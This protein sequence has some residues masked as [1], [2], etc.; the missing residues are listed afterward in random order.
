MNGEWM[1]KQYLLTWIFK[2]GHGICAFVRTPSRDGMLIDCGGSHEIIDALDEY[3]LPSC[4]EHENGFLD[5]TRTAQ[6]LISHP[7]VDHFLQ[8][9][10][11]KQLRPCFWTCP[12]DKD[13]LLGYP[14]ERLDWQLV[15][16]PDG[17][18][19]LEE[20]YRDA[21]SKRVLPLQAFVPANEI[22]HFSYGL[23]Y[24]PPPQ[25]KPVEPKVTE[26][27]DPLPKRDYAN[28]TS[29]MAYF[30]FNK[31]SILMPGDMMESG[32]ER[33]LTVGC[34]SRIVGDD[35]QARFAKQSAP[36][37]TF[38]KWVNR[39]CSVLV[40]PHH[41]L[42]SAYSPE[43]FRSLPAADPRVG[44][45]IISEKAE[46]G[47]SDGKLHPNYQR[48]DAGKVRGALV[49]NPKGTIEEKLSVTT[50]QDGHCLLGFRGAD[51]I[52]VVVSHDLVW[53][54]TKGPEYLFA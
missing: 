37:E 46:P 35:I 43:F 2:V 13:S 40:A 5:E 32:M 23:F 31:N 6:V 17:S 15:S 39:G 42:E 51:E 8:I 47:P 33:A 28:N 38:R 16:N 19:D 3:L 29:I 1:K 36:P 53:I 49:R 41:G 18:K 24:I 26:E 52:G 14:D 4:R 44:L 22:P 7:H 54:L 12:H 30:R 45:V 48:R 27:Y 20:A 25:C 21:Y 10:R 34:E 50:R 9:E 11:A